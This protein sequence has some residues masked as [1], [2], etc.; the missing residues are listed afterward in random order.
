MH[1]ANDTITVIALELAELEGAPN[2]DDALGSI[3][4][5]GDETPGDASDGFLV[6]ALV[7][8]GTLIQMM[9]GLADALR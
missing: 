7:P 9:P 1:C 4:G 2:L 8:I 5:A 6:E 3:D